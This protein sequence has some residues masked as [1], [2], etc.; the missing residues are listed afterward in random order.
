[1]SAR[2][3]LGRSLWGTSYGSTVGILRS[4]DS[5]FAGSFNP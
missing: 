1:M 5:I 2:V 3:G 4:L